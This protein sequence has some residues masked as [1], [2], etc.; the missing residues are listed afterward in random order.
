MNDNILV[1]EGNGS[2]RQMLGATLRKHFLAMS[3]AEAG[4]GEDALSAI[5]A[6]EGSATLMA[7]SFHTSDSSEF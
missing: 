5:P 7:G 6:F 4:N 2:F 1:V 3:I